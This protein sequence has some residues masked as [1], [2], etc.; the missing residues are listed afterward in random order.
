MKKFKYREVVGAEITLMYLKQWC[1][2]FKFTPEEVSNFKK[3]TI[4]NFIYLIY[5]DGVFKELQIEK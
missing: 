5:E 4:R 2:D 3:N 1:K